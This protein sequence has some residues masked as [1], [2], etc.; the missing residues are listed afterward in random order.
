MIINRTPKK[1]LG[2]KIVFKIVTGFL[3]YLGHL[4]VYGY[5]AYILN[6]H[7]AR[8][9]KLRPRAYIGFR[10]GYNSTNVFNIWIPS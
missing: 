9:K 10:V 5:K 1:K 3:P 2:W 6:K 8:L 4:R 7:I